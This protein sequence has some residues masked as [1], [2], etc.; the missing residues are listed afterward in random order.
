MKIGSSGK[1]MAMTHRMMTMKGRMTTLSHPL[2]P[3]LPWPGTAHSSGLV[4]AH[5]TLHTF[6]KPQACGRHLK[7]ELGWGFVMQWLAYQRPIIVWRLME[8]VGVQA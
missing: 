8:G 6:D 7:H 2:A 1:G 4:V 3:T 5:K